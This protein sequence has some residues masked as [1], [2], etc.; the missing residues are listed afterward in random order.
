MLRSLQ[1]IIFFI[2]NLSGSVTGATQQ[3]KNKS[4][5]DEELAKI[6]RQ[7]APY[8]IFDKEQTEFPMNPEIFWNDEMVRDYAQIMQNHVLD[9][10][11]NPTFYQ[12]TDCKHGRIA[13]EYW[14]F[15]GWQGECNKITPKFIRNKYPKLSSI[16]NGDWENII[17][18]VK[19]TIDKG[20]NKYKLNKV[21]YNAHGDA[22]T[23]LKGQFKLCGDGENKT[24]PAVY[25]GLISHGSY[26]NSHQT[27]LF[28][29]LFWDDQRNGNGETLKTENNL[30]NLKE[31]Q[32][33]WCVYYRSN[34]TA[35]YEWGPNGHDGIGTNP[36]SSLSFEEKCN[37]PK[38][39]GLACQKSLHSKLETI[40]SWF[41]N[42]ATRI[43][44][45]IIAFICAH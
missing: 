21:I 1:I 43:M 45:K 33:D 16:H 5:V 36:F 25:P 26:H 29:C 4:H 31:C 28:P 10:K 35:K 39:E 12:I 15:Y 40:D 8:L 42:L 34:I 2:L 9:T 3:P 20:Q 18:D 7:F 32:D 23:K 41:V 37:P 11:T 14:F 19:S 17:V 24:H 27:L 22:Y 38:C 6:S 30:I 13:I 44:K